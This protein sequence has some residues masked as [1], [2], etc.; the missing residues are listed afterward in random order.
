MKPIKLII[1][2]I[3]P[4]AGEMPEIRFD[5]FEEKGLFLLS[6]DTGAGKTTIFDA[7]CY[8]LYGSTSGTYRD[9]KN[10]RSDYAE[11]GVQSYVDFYFSHQ[12]HE[13]HIWRKPPYMRKKLRGQG[14]TPELEKAILYY[15]DGMTVEGITEVNAEVEKLLHINEKQFKQIAMI[16]QGEFWSLLNAKTEQRTEILRTIFMTDGYKSIEAKLKDRM[17]ASNE[18]R[19]V[20]EKSILQYF[21]DV[22]AD[23]ED[24]N[25]EEL[26]DF[27]EKADNTGSAW[28]LDDLLAVLESIIISDKE[29]QECIEKEL[30]KEEEALSKIKDKY[31]KAEINNDFIQAVLDLEKK[32]K[33]LDEKKDEI[34]ALKLLVDKQ[35]K[36]TRDVNPVYTDWNGKVKDVSE[37]E[38]SIASNQKSYEEKKVCCESAKEELKQAESRSGELDKLKV[39]IHKISEEKDKYQQRDELKS[40]L[41]ELENKK[42]EN[43]KIETELA[44]KEK[45]LSDRIKTLTDIVTELKDKPEELS[46]VKSYS[47]KLTALKKD[48]DTILND[49]E[50]SKKQTALEKAQKELESSLEE[51]KKAAEARLHA[52]ISMDECRAGILAKDLKEGEKCPVC[53][54]THHPELAKLSESSVTEDEF[55]ALKDA[56]TKAGEKKNTDNSKAAACKASLEEYENQMH[57]GIFECFESDIISDKSDKIKEA[58]ENKEETDLDDMLKELA[59]VQKT[60]HSEISENDKKKAALEADCDRYRKASEDLSKAQGMDK[61]ALVNDKAT[62]GEAM[63]KISSSI[64]EAKASLEAIKNLSYP[65]WKTAAAKKEEAEKEVKNIEDSI[66]NAKE[67]KDKAEKKLSS[68]EGTLNTLNSGL[69]DQKKAEAEAKAKLDEILKKKDF[70]SIEKMLEFAVTEAEIEDNEKEINDYDKEVSTNKVLLKKAKDAAKGLK[71]IDIESLKQDCDNQQKKVEEIRQSSNTVS[72]RINN[73]KQKQTNI[74]S[75]KDGLNDSRKEY[76]ICKK[77]YDLVKG[78]TGKGKITLEQYIQAAGFDGIIAAANRRLKPMSAG[79]YELYRQEDS[80][81]KKSNNFLDLE[82]LDNFTGHRRPVGNLSGGESFKASLSLALGLS[83]TVSQN[84][85]GIQ[86]DALFIDEGFGTLDRKSIDNALD[87][88]MGLSN[89]NKLVGVISHREELI[90]SIPQQI[91]VTKTKDGSKIEIETGI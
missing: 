37:T 89:T 53:G 45:Q 86:M 55:N 30:N 66:K 58:L 61:D 52:E 70:E 67:A 43:Q 40:T 15:E 59:D 91:H 23:E 71:V 14:F 42:A 54:S 57:Q 47:E 33:E 72:N 31:S 32:K 79:Q 21:R 80:L 90:E 84:I 63:S 12:G 5:Q 7:I 28:N 29:R 8:A 76:N 78:N 62:L 46:K 75:K 34:E 83:D 26:I 3:G 77:L 16:A 56:E 65:D 19:N 44:E 68:L 85:G 24:E 36:A 27:Q 87:I 10:L 6:G 18:R 25:Y 38:A 17:D 39:V 81:G 20:S 88:L 11:E 9:T 35:K 13:Y 22:I 64:A 82:V 49:K 48:I 4:Y 51:Y 60:I 1:S 73:N 41:S 74:L 2:A 69:K 50:R